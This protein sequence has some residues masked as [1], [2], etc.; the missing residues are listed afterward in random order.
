MR[1]S[2]STTSRC[3]ASSASAT[4]GPTIIPPFASSWPARAI[5]RRNKA[6]HA[7]AAVIVEHRGEKRARGFMRVRAEAGKRL[8]DAFGLQP[9]EIHRELLAL[10]RNEQETMAAVVRTFLLQHIAF[11]D[12][13]L[14]H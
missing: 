12:E 1:R 6:Q 10:G 2:S 5:G 9:C 7:L 3:G 8:R 4:A 14:E 13:L 11:I